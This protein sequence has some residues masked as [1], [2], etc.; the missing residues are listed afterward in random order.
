MNPGVVLDSC[1]KGRLAVTRGECTLPLLLTNNLIPGVFPALGNAI[2]K[3]DLPY[4]HAF[5]RMRGT[6][7]G[8]WTNHSPIFSI[9]SNPALKQHQ[10]R[11]TDIMVFGSES[12]LGNEKIFN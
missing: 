4:A 2:L 8:G 11:K 10:V 1:V 7:V 3:V 6:F 9:L 12:S 5:F